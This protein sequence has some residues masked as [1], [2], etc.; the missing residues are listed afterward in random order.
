MRLSALAAAL[1]A[2]AFS[3]CVPAP[4]SAV[5]SC[6]LRDGARVHASGA[7]DCAGFQEVSDAS[8]D[9]LVNAGFLDAPFYARLEGNTVFWIH[10]DADRTLECQGESGLAG[11]HY[12]TGSEA[13]VELTRGGEA[14]AHEMLHAIDEE[15]LGTPQAASALHSGWSTRGARGGKLDTAN[16]TYLEGSWTDIS[17][18]AY[19]TQ[20]FRVHP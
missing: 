3:A 15:A 14:W 11:C 9:A 8:R 13:W 7:Q 2:G 10:S 4:F 17:W 19:F 18:R 6:V 12:R 5:T 16:G 1:L 20:Y